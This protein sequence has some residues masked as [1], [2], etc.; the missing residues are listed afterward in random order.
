MAPKRKQRL[1]TFSAMRT[2]KQ[3]VS[4][5]ERDH[6]LILQCMRKKIKW[7]VQTGEPIEK[8]GEQLLEFPLALS[9]HNGV[10]FKGH[11]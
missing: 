10:P 6:K 7:S 5:L 2:S 1:Q 9:D 8:P 11:I 3:R 4:Q